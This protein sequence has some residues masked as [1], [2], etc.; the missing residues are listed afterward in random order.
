MVSTRSS[1][2]VFPDPRIRD[3]ALTL[4][5]ADILSPRRDRWNLPD[6]FSVGWLEGK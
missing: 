4:N 3:A 6:K 5:P 1:L 2:G